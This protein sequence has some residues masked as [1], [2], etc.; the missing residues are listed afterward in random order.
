M[1]FRR[2]LFRS[3]FSDIANKVIDLK[4]TGPFITSYGITKV[5]YPINS[6]YVLEADRLFQTTDVINSY[7]KQI[8]VYGPG[9]IKYVDFNGDHILDRKRGVVGKSVSEGLDL[10]GSRIIKK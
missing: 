4:G 8:G 9:D 6:R 2:V 10:G 3:N 7:P 5:G 1:E